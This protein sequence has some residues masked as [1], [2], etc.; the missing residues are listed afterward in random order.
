M[1]S[2]LAASTARRAESSLSEPMAGFSRP[3]A[4]MEGNNPEKSLKVSFVVANEWC[5]SIVVLKGWDRSRQPNLR[6]MFAAIAIT[7]G[8][9]EPTC[10]LV[11][12]H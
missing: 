4:P 10:I 5:Q 6:K 3:A 7:Q 1:F 8:G 12:P 2:E 11:Q 9:Q